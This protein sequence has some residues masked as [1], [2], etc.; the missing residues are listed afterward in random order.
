MSRVSLT[1]AEKLAQLRKIP[2]GM[3]PSTLKY[4]LVLPNISEIRFEYSRN[5]K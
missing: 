4:N 5:A 2:L 1:V 3:L